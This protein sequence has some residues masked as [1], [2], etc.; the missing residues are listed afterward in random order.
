MYRVTYVQDSSDITSLAAE[1]L[2]HNAAIVINLNKQLLADVAALENALTA[3]CS[4]IIGLRRRIG[5]LEAQLQIAV[6]RDH[7]S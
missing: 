3:R 4:E 7:A 2:L 6:Q 1:A 5:Y